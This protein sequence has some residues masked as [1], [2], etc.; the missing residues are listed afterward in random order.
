ME[1]LK[2]I[3]EVLTLKDTKRTGWT[4]KEVPNSESVA[5]HL[6]G[7]SFLALTVPLPKNIQR[8]K[9]VKMALV[10][11]IGEVIIG[12]QVWES[13][14]LSNVS[15]YQT[16][17]V[18]E[19]NSIMTLFDKT[20]LDE[21][22]ALALECLQQKTPEAK[23]LK[24]LDKLEM[25]LQALVYEKR[26]KPEKLNEF[27]ENAERYIK[28]PVLLTYFQELQ[29][30][31]VTKGKDGSMMKDVPDNA[32]KLCL[33]PCRDGT[34][35]LNRAKY[36]GYCSKHNNGAVKEENDHENNVLSHPHPSRQLRPD[37]I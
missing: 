35:C 9:L 34:S 15:K 37:K 16:K 13:G 33:A 14:K 21:I 28:N 7:I 6:F 24:E 10:E 31:R 18:H 5:E 32:T 12:D 17:K 26:V 30:E 25:V 27:W 3:R 11:D 1:R 4:Y 36:E 2:L 19:K 20:G 23:F 22:K 8:D 29:K